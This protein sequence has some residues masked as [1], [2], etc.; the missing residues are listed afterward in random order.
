VLDEQPLAG[1]WREDAQRVRGECLERVAQP[2]ARFVAALGQAAQPG[3]HVG[4]VVAL[5]APDLGHDLG[6]SGSKDDCLSASRRTASA[7]SYSQRRAIE[8]AQS[9]R[10]WSSSGVAVV[11]RLAAKG[12]PIGAVAG[13]LG[14][15]IS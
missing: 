10:G 8:N 5:L 6:L 12:E 7:V 3:V 11:L 4:Q 1:E 14:R 13:Q 15:R 2:V 9:V